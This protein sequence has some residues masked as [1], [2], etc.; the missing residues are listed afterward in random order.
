MNNTTLQPMK[1][2]M[3]TTNINLLVDMHNCGYIET[4]K[5]EVSIGFDLK[6][7][8]RFNVVVIKKD[9]GKII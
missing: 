6:G 9:G 2:E 4:T 3:A 1:N 7:E 5:K 8:F